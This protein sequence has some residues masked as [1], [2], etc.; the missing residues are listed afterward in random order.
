MTSYNKLTSLVSGI[1]K[2]KS[3]AAQRQNQ[4]IENPQINMNNISE[5]VAD[6]MIRWTMEGEISDSELVRQIF[7]LL[8]RQFNSVEEVRI[9]A[10]F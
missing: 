1:S 3:A 9:L 7:F 10:H 4:P 6:A 5:I 2:K 8:H